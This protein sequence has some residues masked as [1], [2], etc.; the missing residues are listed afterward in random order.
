MTN[1]AE[2]TVLSSLTDV[3][4]LDELV[5][6]GFS[7]AASRAVLPTELV[8][9]IVEWAIKHYYAS[10]RKVAP[11]KAAIQETWGDQL[12]AMELVIED[13]VEIDSIGWALEQLRDNHARHEGEKLLK[14]VTMDLAAAAPGAKVSEIQN[15]AA[16]FYLLGQGL[17][18][19][20]QEALLGFA[21]EDALDRY[22]NLAESGDAIS[23]LTLGLPEIDEHTKGIRPGEV[24][25][26]AAYSGVGKSWVAA[27]SMLAEWRRGR[28][29]VLFTLE[30]DLAMTA[31]RV[32][33]MLACVDY[34]RWQS[35]Q[36]SDED[37]ARV[38]KRTH[39][40]KSSEHAPLVVMPDRGE[41]DPITLVRK[42]LSKGADSLIIDQ[43]SH[44]ILPGGKRRS[45]ARDEVAEKMELLV[46]QVQ[47]TEPLPCLL[48]H[49]INRAGNK[50]AAKT[51]RYTMDALADSA[52][53]E[54]E[55]SHVF[56]IYRSDV[57][58]ASNMAQLQLLKFRR[59]VEK[60]WE[61]HWRPQ[62]GHIE[63]SR[64]V[65]WEGVPA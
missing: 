8:R 1:L 42:A 55:A 5:K 29:T 15:A 2:D 13:E 52:R 19:R 18:S 21:M 40:I 41:R 34:E 54:R 65:K 20:R 57:M 51:G 58:R 32:A 24:A 25:V 44:M 37:Q 30:N 61:L 45:E 48:M 47:G 11:S 31:D 59:G 23:G 49:Q 6:E 63:V 7:N 28:K 22:R 35:L 62:V 3:D 4:A 46:S 39:E 60:D 64:E 17:T 12:E 14:K 16:A 9:E 26:M 43:L 53:V 50:D 38:E 10:G 36:V 33:C 56:A 27:W